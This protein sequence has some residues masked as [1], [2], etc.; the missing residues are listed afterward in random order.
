MAW[1]RKLVSLVF[2]EPVITFWNRHVSTQ[3]SSA[4]FRLRR[5]FTPL[6]NC[7][8]SLFCDRIFILAGVYGVVESQQAIALC[9]TRPNTRFPLLS[10]A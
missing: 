5:I 8:V 10:I 7:N 6:G 1:M 3:S 4:P 2:S 9:E